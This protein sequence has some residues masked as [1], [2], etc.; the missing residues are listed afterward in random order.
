MAIEVVDKFLYQYENKLGLHWP[1]EVTVDSVLAEEPQVVSSRDRQVHALTVPKVFAD[2]LLELRCDLV[3]SLVRMKL[4][5][6]LDPI[7]ATVAFNPQQEDGSPEFT[8]SK[9]QLTYAQKVVDVWVADGVNRLDR[10]MA[11]E[12]VFNWLDSVIRADVTDISLTPLELILG[13]SLCYAQARRA[14]MTGYEH[15]EA[16]VLEKITKLL[17]YRD[18][19]GRLLED[20]PKLYLDLPPLPMNDSKRALDLFAQKTRQACKLLSFPIMPSLVEV[21]GR[22]VWRIEDL[23]AT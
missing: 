21:E 19:A 7:F 12:A 10:R 20:M 14:N 3:S 13:Y 23:S 17:S 8:E 4:A 15:K 18:D 11:E 5:E 1:V 22:T 6:S 9:K 2:N 16:R